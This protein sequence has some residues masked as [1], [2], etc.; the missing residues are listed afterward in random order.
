MQRRVTHQHAIRQAQQFGKQAGRQQMQQAAR[1]AG[2]ARPRGRTVAKEFG[3]SEY[4]H[5]KLLSVDLGAWIPINSG[6]TA[7]SLR[8]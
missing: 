7:S 8:T 2:R 4:R 3:R 6:M 5:E 1:R